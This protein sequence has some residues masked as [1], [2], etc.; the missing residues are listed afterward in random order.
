V[1]EFMLALKWMRE[2]GESYEQNMGVCK[3]S[4]LNMP[5]K[6]YSAKFACSIA[7]V[8]NATLDRGQ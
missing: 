8:S 7:Q 3:C 5:P 1:K 6:E 2:G 4:E